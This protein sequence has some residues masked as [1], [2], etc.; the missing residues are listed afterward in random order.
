MSLD[1]LNNILGESLLIT[2]GAGFIASHL[3][4]T[5]LEKTEAQVKVLD[6]LSTG[7]MSN[8][9]NCINSPKFSFIR[10]DLD[11]THSIEDALE[12]VTTLFHAAADPEV[13]TGYNDPTISFNQNIRNTFSLLDCARKS[14]VQ[15]I[16][17]FSSSTIYGEPDV[18]PTTE[19]YG[20]LIPISHYGASK[21][22]CEAYVSSF[23]KTYGISSQIYRLANIIGLRS[24]HGVIWDFV[25]KL[26][27]DGKRLEILGDGKQTKSYIHV[28]DCIDCILFSLSNLSK[29]VE[30]FNIGNIDKI[31]VLSIATIV[32]KVM[33]LHDVQFSIVGGT[34]N[35]KGWIG[36]V[37]FMQLDISK[38][39]RM[40]W[41]PKL[42]S[43]QAVEK[44][45][46]EL[47]SLS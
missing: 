43:S 5:I 34:E 27:Q 7:T 29:D 15:N 9:S 41:V 35:G 44:S 26:N 28:D 38:L 10:G 8:L 11:Q 18:I 1:D 39:A 46:E 31:D 20:P 36:D 25:T 33:G 6:N 21:L 14:D 3:A 32:S 12:G 37:K 17:F 45:C 22:A 4:D 16:H 42:S 19:D 24:G 40:G 30:I 47:L 23:S 2:G 13:R